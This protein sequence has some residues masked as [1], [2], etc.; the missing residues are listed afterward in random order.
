[1]GGPSDSCFAKKLYVYTIAHITAIIRIASTA[2]N[3]YRL[4]TLA[5]ACSYPSSPCFGWRSVAMLMLQLSR[6]PRVMQRQERHFLQFPKIGA[7]PH[8]A[9]SQHRQ[10]IHRV[11][12]RTLRVE[13]RH[14]KQVNINK[15]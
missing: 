12:S 10:N 2:P 7:D 14:N 3:W 13:S 15:T 8:A 9:D 4:R 6:K 5:S 11:N 1:M